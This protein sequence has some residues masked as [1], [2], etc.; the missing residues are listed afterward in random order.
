MGANDEKD[1]TPLL[2]DPVTALTGEELPDV[3]ETVTVVKYVDVKV[4]TVVYVLVSVEV[5]DV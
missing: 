4:D 1:S 5:P 2:E 3:A